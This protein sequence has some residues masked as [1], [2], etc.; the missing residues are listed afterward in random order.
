MEFVQSGVSLSFEVTFDSPDLYVGMAV[1]DDSGVSPFLVSVIPM[2][3]IYGNT[4][5]AKFTPSAGKS[6]LF[7]K[8]VYTDNTYTIFDDD[9]SQ[10]SESIRA[11]DIAG[12]VLNPSI[13][14]YQIVGSVGQAILLASTRSG[15]GLVMNGLPL[16]ASIEAVPPVR[17]VVSIPE[18]IGIV[19][20]EDI[21]G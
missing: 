15:G 1:I 21:G 18:T 10:G 6:Y 13:Y 16:R 3:N 8:A 4:Y 12:I 20:S 5:R 11:D 9:Y 2:Q 17:G 7:N 19:E 14:S